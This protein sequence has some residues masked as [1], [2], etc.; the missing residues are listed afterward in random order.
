MSALRDLRGESREGARHNQVA[1]DAALPELLTRDAGRDYNIA[2]VYAG[3]HDVGA[4]IS[5]LE[6]A[7]TAHF[8][9]LAEITTDPAFGVIRDAPALAR[10][11]SCR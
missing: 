8:R 6:R 2:T 5:W 1:A 10:F 3:R 7:R 9:G 11:V 4:A